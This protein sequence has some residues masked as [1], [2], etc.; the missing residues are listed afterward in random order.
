LKNGSLIQAVQI[1]VGKTFEKS[2]RVYQMEDS[3]LVRGKGRPNKNIGQIMK[4]DV[5]LNALSLNMVQHKILLRRL[6]HV[7][8][9]TW[10]NKALVVAVFI[11]TY[12][13]KCPLL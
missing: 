8:N 6:N 11:V 2:I 7:V 12:S 10:W 9:A 1:Y 5:E 13:A 3:Q 4:R